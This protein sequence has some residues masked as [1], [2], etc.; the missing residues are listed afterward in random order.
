MNWTN[1]AIAS[2]SR[3]QP[4]LFTACITLLT[5]TTELRP[6]TEMD[7]RD[8]TTREAVALLWGGWGVLDS[9]KVKGAPTNHPAGIQMNTFQIR[10]H[11]ICFPVSILGL[12]LAT[13]SSNLQ[14]SIP[15][16]Q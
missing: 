16:R 9:L 2:H 3:S 7:D 11:E 4:W 15:T 5:A 13:T 1:R 14:K 10:H 8:S 6:P 12:L